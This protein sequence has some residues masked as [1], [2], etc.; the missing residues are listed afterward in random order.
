MP[1]GLGPTRPSRS[2]ARVEKA[3]EEG[4]L[5]V[6]PWGVRLLCMSSQGYLGREMRVA[7]W[8]YVFGWCSYTPEPGLL[9]MR[10]RA[11]GGGGGRGS[12]DTGQTVLKEH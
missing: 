2:W 6:L 10:G 12:Q 1:L 9:E 5:A 11:R 4:M 8:A 7:A 3:L